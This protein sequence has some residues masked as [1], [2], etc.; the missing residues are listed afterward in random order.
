MWMNYSCCSR[1]TAALGIVAVGASTVVRIGAAG[2]PGQDVNVSGGSPAQV[3]CG[4]TRNQFQ[5][6]ESS[7]YYESN[8][9][10]GPRLALAADP[11]RGIGSATDTADGR[12]AVPTSEP[13]RLT[14]YGSY[15]TYYPSTDSDPAHVDG[16]CTAA[17]MFNRPLLLG[18]V[19]GR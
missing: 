10:T 1:L 15:Q 6:I 2:S 11:V 9:C 5:A 18:P 14:T 3:S 19:T 16:I 13:V 7:Y 17:N 8:D 12:A 4:T